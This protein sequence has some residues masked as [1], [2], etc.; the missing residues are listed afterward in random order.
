[1]DSVIVPSYI[2][3]AQ[4]LG[5]LSCIKLNPNLP[6]LKK[7]ISIFISLR[8]SLLKSQHSVEDIIPEVFD[9]KVI[10]P[11]GGDHVSFFIIKLGEA[12]LGV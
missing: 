4:H 8:P 11:S 6:W 9:S 7:T 12:V 3:H 5:L 10:F 1:M 2:F